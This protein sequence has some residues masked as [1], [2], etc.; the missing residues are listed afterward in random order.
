M[1]EEGFRMQIKLKIPKDDI[2]KYSKFDV[3]FRK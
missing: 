1:F 3:S 2:A